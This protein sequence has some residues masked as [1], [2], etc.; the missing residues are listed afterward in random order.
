VGVGGPRRQAVVARLLMDRRAVVAADVLAD[1]VWDGAP[2]EAGNANLHVLVSKLRRA[3]GEAGAGRGEVLRTVPPGYVL[4]VGENACDIGR[5]EAFRRA[6]VEAAAAGA[7]ERAAE[8]FAAALAQWRGEAFASVRGIGWFDERARV[9]GDSRGET[10][11]ALVDAR[12]AVG[13]WGE[14]VPD[15]LE[16]LQDDPY[17]ERHWARLILA[18]AA[19]GRTAAALDSCRRMREAFAVELGVEPG[20][21]LV[22]LERRVRA[23]TV[24]PGAVPGLRTTIGTG[25]AQARRGRVRRLPD[26]AVFPVGRR[27]LRIGR[28]PDNDLVLGSEDVSRYHAEILFSRVGPVIRDRGSLNLTRVR[29]GDLP[30]GATEL[31][32]H[33]DEIEICGATFVFEVDPPGR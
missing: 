26:G 17:A 30:R 1:A 7:H 2:P 14:V 23:G 33:G 9:L 6:G 8:A 25:S 15:L 3:L 16:L 12:L 5:F 13:R 20:A 11:S 4:A 18:Q 21:A 22:E 31:L 27:G 24:S 19:S 32:G 29:G 28:A 10:R